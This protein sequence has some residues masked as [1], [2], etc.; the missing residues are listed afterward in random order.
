MRDRT[1][2]GNA[3]VFPLPATQRRGDVRQSSCDRVELGVSSAEKMA[4]SLVGTRGLEDWFAKRGEGGDG[5]P[6]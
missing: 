2:A 1:E 5:K 3:N 4:C 6:D